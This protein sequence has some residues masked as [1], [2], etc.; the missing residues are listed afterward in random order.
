[1][2]LGYELG[3]AHFLVHRFGAVKFIGQEKWIV[4]DG[5]KGSDYLSLP[6]LYDPKYVL[7]A[8]DASGTSLMYEGL[9]NM[10]QFNPLL[11]MLDLM[12]CDHC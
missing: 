2:T 4:R 6:N 11:Q 5:E 10:S 9:Q 3:A 7:E 1:M 8:I 12:H